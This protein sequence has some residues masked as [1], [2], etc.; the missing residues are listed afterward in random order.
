M[1]E[2]GKDAPEAPSLQPA[3]LLKDLLP[4]I[5]IAGDTSQGGAAAVAACAAEEAPSESSSAPGENAARGENA[6][7]VGKGADQSPVAPRLRG[8][9]IESLGPGEIL[10]PCPT[11]LEPYA[12]KADVLTSVT[13]SVPGFVSDFMQ[14][15]LNTES[16]DLFNIWAGLFAVAVLG[17]RQARFKWAVGEM[18]PNLYVLLIADPAKCHK[19]AAMGRASRLLTALPSRYME[20][21]AAWLA[22]EKDIE[23]ISSKATP[24]GLLIPMTP[25][26]SMFLLEEGKI[27]NENFGSRAFVWSEEFATFLN[28]RKYNT[29]LVDILT[30]FYDCPLRDKQFTQARGREAYERIF[31]CVAG[32]MTPAHLQR[33]M[34]EEIYTGGFMSR[35]V[36]VHVDEPERRVAI[37]DP[38][39]APIKE[40]ELLERLAFLGWTAR[41]EYYFTPEAEV[42]YIKWY[43]EYKDRV[44]DKEVGITDFSKARFE[45]LL[46]R[47]ATL[48]RMSEYRPGNDVTLADV[49]A[50]KDL[51]EYTLKKDDSIQ[52]AMQPTSNSDLQHLAFVKRYLKKQGSIERGKLVR[53]LSKSGIS[54]NET[55][56]ILHQLHEEGRVE[57]VLH[58]DVSNRTEPSVDQRELY[59]WVR[60][61]SDPEDDE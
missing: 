6:A 18:I 4:V 8:I 34:P 11:P 21:G 51:L 35:V 10:L 47:V 57:F 61:E 5:P 16:P 58:G 17:A 38:S 29:G 15:F 12:F 7:P 22:Q 37:P 32:A 42:W 44:M 41:G 3:Y 54:A 60:V 43:N 56:V 1:P 2:I 50:A 52:Y 40:T 27:H 53:K 26:K 9:E 31:L 49:I 39:K 20:A 55:N 25:K 36:M 48:F 46:I 45:H 23:M 19:G 13:A 14:S 24:D 59:K 30:Y 28:A 33:S